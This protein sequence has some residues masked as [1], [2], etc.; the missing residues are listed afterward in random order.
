M[1]RFSMEDM[2]TPPPSAAELAHLEI[3]KK[4]QDR[5]MLKEQRLAKTEDRLEK[6]RQDAA[7]KE[8]QRRSAE[9]QARAQENAH[10]QEQERK[11]WV[12]EEL[13][14]DVDSAIIMASAVS[15]FQVT[16]GQRQFLIAFVVELRKA[17]I[18]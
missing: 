15:E 3:Q 5:L 6:Q 13:K 2:Q 9:A 4:K 10:K 1:P 16:E 18:L 12:E 8:R 14:M 11:S 7:R 17:K